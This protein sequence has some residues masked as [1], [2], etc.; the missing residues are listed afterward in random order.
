MTQEDL[1]NVV[2]TLHEPSVVTRAD[3]HFEFAN[4][5]F[6]NLLRAAG[7]PDAERLHEVVVDAPSDVDA[8][9]AQAARTRP[10]IQGRLTFTDGGEAHRA[11]CFGGV[12]HAGADIGDRLVL[13]R[14]YRTH[15]S[16]ERF[17]LL[18]R[19]IDE[20]NSEIRQ[21][22]LAEDEL[23]E[24]Q[25]SLEQRVKART[26]ELERANREL[27]R[28]NEALEEFAYV[29]SHDLRDPLR[30]IT[31]FSEM[32]REEAGEQL[33]ESSRNILV[34]MFESAARMDALVES[35]LEYSRVS[36]ASTQFEQVDLKKI[37]DD[38]VGDLEVK[39]AETDA[40]IEAVDLPVV[41]ADEMQMRQLFQNLISNGLKFRRPD[42]VPRVR[43]AASKRRDSY[44][45]EHVVEVS[46]N[47]IGFD[48]AFADVIFDPFRRLEA[49]E[50]F[51][52]TGIGLA[53]CRRIVERHGG[54]ISA[55]SEPDQ[56]A[57]F[58]V[59]LPSA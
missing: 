30:K 15:E 59:A 42:V 52:G 39:V 53:V 12:L 2:A 9:L 1:R 33:S 29:A 45:A 11:T 21:R 48:P 34:R 32:L 5:A 8:F 31:L 3:G 26:A 57:T 18:G 43:I 19:K 47:G 54:T 24:I 23:R 40:V 58:R 46:D 38:V 36:T 44:Q 25:E 37:V 50:D 49:R 16:V 22:R 35:L 28:S 51:E 13:L 27:S 17:Q 4:D 56:G 20:L 7:R 6:R 10:A 14:F 41:L 55:I